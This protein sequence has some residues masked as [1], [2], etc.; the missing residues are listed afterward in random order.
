MFADLNAYGYLFVNGGASLAISSSV[1][2]PAH[3]RHREQRRCLA[4]WQQF[5]LLLLNLKTGRIRRKK[6]DM[7][8]GTAIYCREVFVGVELLKKMMQPS[9]ARRRAIWK[10]YRQRW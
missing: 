9:Y 10:S 4:A 2:W 6:G 8:P 1:V 3:P 5:P 7:A